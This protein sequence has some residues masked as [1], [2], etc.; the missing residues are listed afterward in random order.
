MIPDKVK[1]PP[2]CQVCHHQ[3]RLDIQKDIDDAIL[4]KRQIAEK[5]GVS[6]HSITNHISQN[7]RERL[8]AW[9]VMDYQV[10]KAGFDI[11]ETLVAY[12][13]R[14]CVSLQQRTGEEIRDSDALK[15]LE[16]LMKFRGEGKE[17]HEVTVK[18]S[19]GEMIKEYLEEEDENGKP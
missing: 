6:I 10:R 5:Y 16:M 11:G 14:W 15:A 17:V 2:R 13:K 18:K 3:R 8:I 12:L 9:S 7:H 1:L 19:L 4:T